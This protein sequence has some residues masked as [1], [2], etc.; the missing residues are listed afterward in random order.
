MN[1]T[2]TLLSLLSLTALAQDAAKVDPAEAPPREGAST[3]TRK[4]S[5]EKKEKP[6]EETPAP[7]PAPAQD[8]QP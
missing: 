6:T 5:G 1:R 8:K 3:V 7:A 4:G 2:V